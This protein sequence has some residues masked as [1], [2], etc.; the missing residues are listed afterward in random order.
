MRM[1]QV[2]YVSQHRKGTFTALDHVNDGFFDLQ[3]PTPANT[4]NHA[5]L[6]S[7]WTAERPQ[8]D[9]E[10]EGLSTTG[11]DIGK[12]SP[13]RLPPDARPDIQAEQN[14]HQP[15]GQHQAG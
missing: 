9:W 6:N 12:R 7:R 2:G 4:Q 1:K 14:S 15:A 10:K 8:Y 5:L 11:F 3:K 13:I